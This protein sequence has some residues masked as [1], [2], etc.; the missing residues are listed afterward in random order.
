MEPDRAVEFIQGHQGRGVC[1]THSVETKCVSER[2]FEKGGPLPRPIRTS[3]SLAV[4]IPGTQIS[5]SIS[6]ECRASVKFTQSN[7]EKMNLI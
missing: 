4:R 6:M 7:T 2:C 1:D 5:L 3:R